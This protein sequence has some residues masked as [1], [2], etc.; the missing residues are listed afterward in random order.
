MK[1][2]EDIMDEEVKHRMRRMK[3]ADRAKDTDRLWALISAAA[4]AACIKCFRLEGIIAKDM[5][6]RGKVRIETVR[7]E[8][9]EIPEHMQGNE[10]ATS[11]EHIRR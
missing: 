7:E 1:D 9:H 5:R 11:I 6:G 8:P 3:V 2:L 4:E 10:N